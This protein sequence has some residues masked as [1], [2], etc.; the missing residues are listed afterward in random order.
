[1]GKKI[2]LNLKFS[3][4]IGLILFLF[5]TLFSTLLYH[6][7]KAQV[8]RDA[9][10]KTMIIMTMVKSIGGYVRETL[11]P[12]VIDVLAKLDRDQFIIE[13]MSTTHV[14]MQVMARFNK[15]IKAYVYKRV[16]DNPMNP[17]NRADF[18]HL[19]MMAHF[20]LNRDITSWDGIVDIDD[21]MYIARLRP[22]V[23]ET[24]C[25]QCHGDPSDAPKEIIER[26]GTGSGFGRRVGTVVGVDYV[27]VPLDI[28]FAQVKSVA[29]YVF[30]IGSSALCF[31]FLAL[32]AT[33]RNI[34]SKPLYKL[35]GI[36][37]GIANGT[38]P[39]G[40]QIQNDRQD[41]IG[42]LTS[43][44]NT[45]SQYL[46]DAQ[47]QLKKV[48]EI[49]KQ[50]IKT[51]KLAALGQLSAGVAHE[52]NNPLGGIKLCFNNVVSTEMDDETK[53][54]HI[55]VIN[56]GFDRIQGIIRHL[57]DFSQKSSLS[58][59]P[60]SINN[61]IEYVLHLI[62]YQISKKNIMVIKN[63]SSDIP[64]ILVDPN[65]IEQV[66]LNMMLNAIQ[67]MDEK[68][69]GSLTIMTSCINGFCEASFKDTGPGIGDE[70]FPR[71]FDPFFTTKSV[72]EGTGLGLS[73]SKSIVEQHG[74]RI[75]AETSDSGTEFIIRLPLV[76]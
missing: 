23:M 49:E 62:D 57:L 1:M 27:S 70:V 60:V 67:A 45:L 39:L 2:G 33:F 42:D 6:Y 12:K 15:D 66:F 48:A 74:G 13:A 25:L 37:K 38:E 51:E 21:N 32:Y 59:M 52:I 16:S 64:D 69:H 30:M 75:D 17:N 35:S 43:S 53:K 28:A 9:E 68:Q 55:D 14:S 26:Y 8:V 46:L 41:E 76:K 72:G 65:K 22:I 44:F 71:I 11:R 50:M 54:A 61:L 5:C 47:D 4:I 29:F 20:R 3:I 40:R 7:L 19:D 73:V 34:V 36:F 58:V 63:L 24:S 31:L 10:E 56:G 18:F